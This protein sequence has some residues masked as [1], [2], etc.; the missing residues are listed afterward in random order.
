[1]RKSLIVGV[2]G[3]CVLL[4][5]LVFQGGNPDRDGRALGVRAA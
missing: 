1:M 4:V 2:V 5:A 3:A